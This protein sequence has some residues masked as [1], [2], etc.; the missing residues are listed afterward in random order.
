MKDPNTW[1]PD[2]LPFSLPLH[3]CCAALSR[4]SNSHH[5]LPLS[6]LR[7]NTP[8]KRL[9]RRAK[10]TSSC[11]WAALTFWKARPGFVPRAVGRTSSLALPSSP[12][13]SNLLFPAV[14]DPSV[15]ALHLPSPHH[16]LLRRP[17][18][19]SK[20]LWFRGATPCSKHL[21]LLPVPEQEVCE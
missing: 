17:A 14:S 21:P 15:P 8:R 10:S 3:Q 7:M 16:L 1:S 6:R 4:R 12:A 20:S 13:Q 9:P 19:D 11:L 18:A 5:T 2:S